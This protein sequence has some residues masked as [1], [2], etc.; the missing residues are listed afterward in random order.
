MLT[1]NSLIA[2][3]ETAL[4]SGTLDKR[5]AS[6]RR[7]TDLFLNSAT[8]LNDEQV[9]LFDTILVQLAERMQTKALSELS[10]RLAPV[11]NAPIGVVQH[12]ARHNDIS[13][14][15]PILSKSER[16]TTADLIEIAKKKG[17]A[18]LL[19]IS[20]RPLLV[21]AITDTLLEHGNNEVFCKLAQ[22]SG[23]AFSKTGFE[24]LTERAKNNEMLAERVGQRADLPQHLLHDLVAKAT[25]A[26]RI[27]LLATA[28]AELHAEIK[29]VLA[30]ISDQVMHESRAESRDIK[31]AQKFVLDLRQ[32]NQLDE[33]VLSDLAKKCELE[34][35][36]A[37]LALMTSMQIELIDHVMHTANY[38]GLL[39]VCKAAGLTWATVD[40]I[41]THRFPD[42]PIAFRDLDQAKADYFYLAKPTAIRL[43]GYWKTQQEFS[44][45]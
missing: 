20:S 15:E 27:K 24:S 18:H 10:Q 16:L 33:S 37:A 42:H 30:V 35:L 34:K 26:V 12:L 45:A 19:A 1:Q 22:N 8:H 11:R 13:V 28:P 40:I 44:P 7:V 31:S 29:G 43:L 38:G 17:H 6:M 32:R 5:I 25:H 39:V 9:E 2:E 4:Q 21:E 41:L 23:A 3:L 36:G 14:A